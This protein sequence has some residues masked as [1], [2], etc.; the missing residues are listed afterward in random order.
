M[1]VNKLSNDDQFRK[2]PYITLPQAQNTHSN[3]KFANHTAVSV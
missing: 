3:E 1:F 2:D